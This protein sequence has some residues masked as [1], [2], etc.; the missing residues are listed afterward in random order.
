MT[1]AQAIASLD[2]Q[3][4]RHGQ[5]ITFH[6]IVNGVPAPGAG[7]DVRAFVRKFEP[8]ELVNG[9][10]QKDRRVVTSPSS[11]AVVSEGGRFVINGKSYRIEAP[12]PVTMDDTVVRWNSVVRG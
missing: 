1:P 12:D 4:A 11:L 9:L 8:D 6:Q 5:T 3:L 7:T 10:T 2:L